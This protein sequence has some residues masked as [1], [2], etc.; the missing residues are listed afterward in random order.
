MNE[1]LTIII[2]IYNSE[3]YLD[4]CL[5]SILAQTYSNYEVL[6]IDDGSTDDSRKICL[7]YCE[8]DK[9]FKYLY[10]NNSGVSD[11]RNLGLQN[12]NGELVCFVDSDD[13]LLENHLSL[14]VSHFDYSIDFISS[15]YIETTKDSNRLIRRM[16][17]DSFKRSKLINLVVSEISV[18]GFCWN[19]MYRSKI[20]RKYKLMFRSD[21][22]VAEDLV[23]NLDYLNHIKDGKVINQC[24]YIYSYNNE[25]VMRTDY[26]YDSL[27]KRISMLEAKKYILENYRELDES[28]QIFLK[29][30]IVLEASYYYR[31]SKIYNYNFSSS[32]IAYIK[33]YKGISNLSK[34]ECL[35]VI[36]NVYFPNIINA[37]SKVKKI[38]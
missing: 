22:H 17:T 35:K 36:F 31:L 34:N 24:N 8:K 10:K 9:R 27:K 14:L 1:F 19:K 15:G 38:R 7:S 2:P 13:Y 12:M 29:K 23:F 37:L 6:L 11:S 3:K 4:R 33:K 16:E 5:R 30:R 20:I 21:I 25:S 26:N 28:T 18:Y 32:L